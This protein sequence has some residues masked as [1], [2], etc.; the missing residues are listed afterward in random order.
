MD[1]T[2]NKNFILTVILT[3]L[4]IIISQGITLYICN[5]IKQEETL[6]DGAII[7]TYLENTRRGIWNRT[8]RYPYFCI[9]KFNCN[10]YNYTFSSTTKRKTR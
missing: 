4:L 3:I 5:N 10:R 8:K 9:S 7:I 1:K 6:F 2:R